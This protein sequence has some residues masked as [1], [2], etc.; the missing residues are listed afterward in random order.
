MAAELMLGLGAPLYSRANFI[1]SDSLRDKSPDLLK[2]IGCWMII[3]RQSCAIINV[4]VLE[5][6]MLSL[7]VKRL[8]ICPVSSVRMNGI[9]SIIARSHREYSQRVL[10][11]TLMQG[12]IIGQRLSDC[13]QKGSIE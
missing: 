3:D 10:M 11:M 7:V 2:S 13:S 4:R 5:T 1:R 8:L 12:C 9:V 6:A